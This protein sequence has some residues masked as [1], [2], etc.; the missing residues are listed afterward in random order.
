[1][2]NNPKYIIDQ[3]NRKITFQQSDLV[4]IMN[5]SF[6]GF[7]TYKKPDG[8]L[9]TIYSNTINVISYLNWSIEYSTNFINPEDKVPVLL[10]DVYSENTGWDPLNNTSIV[11]KI[12]IYSESKNLY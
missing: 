8:T 7:I 11:N 9:T 12:T 3:A 2:D 6:R 5:S 1:M 10:F 4:E